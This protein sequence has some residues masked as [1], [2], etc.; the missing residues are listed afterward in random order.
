MP[1]IR[2]GSIVGATVATAVY[3]FVKRR[4]LRRRIIPSLFFEKFLSPIN[5]KFLQI[6]RDKSINFDKFKKHILSHVL[7]VYF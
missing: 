4:D 2:E 3:I 6:Y 7:A 1:I 5:D